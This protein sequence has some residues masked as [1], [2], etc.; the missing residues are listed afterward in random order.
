MEAIATFWDPTLSCVTIRNV[1]S[2]ST[3]EDYDGFLSLSTPVDQV[4]QPRVR[5]YYRKWLAELIGM[6]MPMVD[7]LTQYGSGLGGSLSLDFLTFQF[8]LAECLV[9]YRRDFKDLRECWT[10]YRFQAF[11]IAFFSFILFPS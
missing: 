2:A 3:L 4:Y 8:S 1:D 5:P 7:I 10:F 11:V 9:A 6:K